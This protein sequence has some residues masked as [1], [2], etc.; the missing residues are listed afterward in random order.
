MWP[1][2]AA[3]VK[4]YG[5]VVDVFVDIHQVAYLFISGLVS[6]IRREGIP[7]EE[8]LSVALH[9]HVARVWAHLKLVHLVG[10]DAVVGVCKV[11]VVGLTHVEHTHILA[12]DEVRDG[13]CRLSVDVE[14]RAVYNLL[15]GSILDTAVGVVAAVAYLQ[16]LVLQVGLVGKEGIVN[17]VVSLIYLARFELEGV[18]C[19]CTAPSATHGEVHLLVYHHAT[20]GCDVLEVYGA[21]PVH[22]PVAGCALSVTRTSIDTLYIYAETV[23]VEVDGVGDNGNDRQCVVSV[24]I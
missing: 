24:F 6:S 7:F 13:L 3:E 5:H 11:L 9:L 21:V 18:G 15:Q 17:R 19:P 14:A 1:V 16:C 4:L 12:I 8:S 2:V 20:I 22:I 10:V 23:V